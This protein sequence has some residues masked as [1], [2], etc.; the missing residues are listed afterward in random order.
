M[1]LRWPAAVLLV[2][3]VGCALVYEGKYDWDEGWRSGHVVHLGKGKQLPPPP[4]GD[5]RQG[6]A[7]SVIE[8][9]LYA[10]VRFQNEGRWIRKS[11]V[12]PPAAGRQVPPGR[13]RLGGGETALRGREISNR[14]PLDPRACGPH[15]RQRRRA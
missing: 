7:A 10:D 15:P 9:T 14:G 13:R 12:T 11:V 2:P 8:K 4:G 5:C 1:V 3:L 6:V